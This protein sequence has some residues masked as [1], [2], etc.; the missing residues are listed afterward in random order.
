M[1]IESILQYHVLR[2]Y[3]NPHEHEVCTCGKGKRLVQCRYDGCFQYPTSCSDCFI[4]AHR[5]N[6]LHWALKWDTEK[7][8]WVQH[9]ISELSATF[10]IQL[11]HVFD[12]EASPCSG[13]GSSIPF[14]IT[15]TNGVHSTRLRFC[16]CLSAE[17]KVPQLMAAQLFP[18]TPSEPESAFTF[19]VLKHFHMHNLQS[20]C[21]AFDYMLSIRRLTDNVFTS[22]VPVSF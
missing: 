6:P 1:D 9:D 16:G 8:F 15:H 13:S 12:N 4:S 19:A 21:G 2:H 3:G 10:A 14:I 11:G 7:Q 20:K 18:G 22:K 17:D 5:N